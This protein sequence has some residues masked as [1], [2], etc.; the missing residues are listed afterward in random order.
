MEQ[1][2]KKLKPAVAQ[3]YDGLKKAD[4]LLKS[5]STDA[6]KTALRTAGSSAEKLLNE[7]FESL[8]S[9]HSCS[10]DDKSDNDKSK[11][12]DHDKP[13]DKH[14]DKPKNQDHDKPQDKP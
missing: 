11:D 3:F 6:A 10:D 5:G 2:A 8:L 12:E 14:H 9:L 13:Q 4:D 1:A 7:L